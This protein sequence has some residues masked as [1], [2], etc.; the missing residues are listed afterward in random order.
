MG[1]K[2]WMLV[3]AEG[4]MRGRLVQTS[5]PDRAATVALAHRLFPGETLEPMEDGS[6]GWTNPPDGELV[7]GSFPGFDVVA[8]K[9]FALDY[10][11]R[12]PEKFIEAA[13]GRTVY[14]HA[15]HSVVD[16]FAFGVWENGRLKRSLSLSPDKGI[17]EDIG[18]RL[19]FEL[20]YWEGKHPLIGPGE[21]PTDYPFVFHP[22]ELGD[23][24]LR[25]L[26]GYYMEGLSDATM[27][28]AETIPLL[29]FRRSMGLN[30]DAR[31]RWWKVW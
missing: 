10:P 22:L 16:W 4:L 25:A 3:Y 7:I 14:L 12:V 8:A 15:M 30:G 1:A 6:L 23:A 21:E 9:E 17:L 29:R 20:P 13:D 2:T 31:W 26:F 24:A 28:H 5:T 11:S 19:A 27:V 18:A